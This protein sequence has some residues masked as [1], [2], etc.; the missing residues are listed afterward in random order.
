MAD[1]SD[2]YTMRA[3]PPGDLVP[4]GQ[5][6][7]LERVRQPTEAEIAHRLAL[8]PQVDK[9]R[10]QIH[11]KASLVP[12]DQTRFK[13]YSRDPMEDTYDVWVEVLRVLREEDRFYH[14]RLKLNWSQVPVCFDIHV[15]PE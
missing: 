14:V 4:I 8:R 12:I 3:C 13:H 7:Y 9:I 6:M 2:L 11:A 15:F 1:L 10:A 5:R